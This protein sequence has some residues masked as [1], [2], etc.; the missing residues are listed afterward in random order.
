M[1]EQSK[2]PLIPSRVMAIGSEVVPREVLESLQDH[3]LH[4]FMR[5]PDPSDWPADMKH[6]LEYLSKEEKLRVTIA[7]VLARHDQTLVSS[8]ENWTR[9]VWNEL[10]SE[11]AVS[12]HDLPL[13]VDEMIHHLKALIATYVEAH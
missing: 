12:A 7:S 1:T 9:A 4:A 10:T 2:K 11:K 5:E 3:Q 8:L 6:M 13:V